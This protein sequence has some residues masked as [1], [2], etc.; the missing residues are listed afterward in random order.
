[1]Q[2]EI[3]DIRDVASFKILWKGW[4][5]CLKGKKSERR[6][7]QEY[8]PNAK[9]NILELQRQLLNG[10]WEPDTGRQ[11]WL[12]TEGK[13][14]LI[15]TVGVN[16]RIVHYAL[17]NTFKIERRFVRRT[18]GS[19]KKRGTLAASKQLRRDIKE[20]GFDICIKLDAKKYYPNINKEI[21]IGMLRKRYKGR[22]ALTLFEK[23]IR[24]YNPEE[25]IGVSIGAL[26]S[27]DIGNFYLTIF[28]YF[29][30]QECGVKRY[31]RY[32]DDMVILVRS[33]R[34]AKRII[35]M[36]VAKAAEFKVTFGKIEV[37][38]ISSR[39]VDFCGYAVNHDTCR[40]RKRTAVRFM[41][42]LRQLDRRASI[43]P[44]Y[45]RSCVCSYLGL[46]EHCNGKEL[47]NLL[48]KEHYEVFRRIDRYATHSGRTGHGAA[49]A[50][51]G[52]DGTQKVF[53][54][55]H[56]KARAGRNRRGDR[57]TVIYDNRRTV[58]RLCGSG[59][60]PQANGRG[61]D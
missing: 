61:M 30:M 9:E 58:R 5:N 60:Q 49:I 14:R 31:V 2:R 19:I 25:L 52:S 12:F 11:F 15:T 42:K 29:V 41:R 21:L 47:L 22:A 38:P 10:T 27:Q 35:P 33:K 43:N 24:S 53:Q 23:V 17:I 7:V 34:E 59:M 48:K 37:F 13:W 54:P 36:L 39:R 51:A 46:L 32:V 26:T 3:V 8:Y 50:A 44:I 40:L 18:Y 16:D 28:D 55:P 6:D 45:E 1:M 56:R 4:Q 57:G 20:S